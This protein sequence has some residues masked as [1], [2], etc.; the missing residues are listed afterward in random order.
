MQRHSRVRVTFPPP[1]ALEV[2][3]AVDPQRVDPDDRVPHFD[4]LSLSQS[5]PDLEEPR[6]GPGLL[7]ENLEALELLA[8]LPLGIHDFDRR[9]VS[10]TVPGGCPLCQW[11][12]AASSALRALSAGGVK[13]CDFVPC[14]EQPRGK[15]PHRREPTAS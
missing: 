5:Q 13:S 15:E 10:G 7:A 12:S 3:F 11:L 4:G 6:S 8:G 9:A 14:R 2:L 1:R